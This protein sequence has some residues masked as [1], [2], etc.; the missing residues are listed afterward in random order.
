M[1]ASSDQERAFSSV[2]LLA[3]GEMEKRVADWHRE[4]V[5]G[6]RVFLYQLDGDDGQQRLW[7]DGVLSI[8]GLHLRFE[9]VEVEEEC[10]QGYFGVLSVRDPSG[11]WHELRSNENCG[12]AQHHLGDRQAQPLCLDFSDVLQRYAD[13]RESL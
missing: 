1:A 4:G 10:E 13:H 2:E 8:H 5:S 11:S 12:C 6:C 7:M 3:A 9:N